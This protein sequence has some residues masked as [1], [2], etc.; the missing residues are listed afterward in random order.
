L[1]KALYVGQRLGGYEGWSLTSGERGLRHACSPQWCYRWAV[2]CIYTHTGYTVWDYYGACCRQCRLSGRFWYVLVTDR[3]TWAARRTADCQ[4]FL[5]CFYSWC[6]SAACVRIDGVV[7]FHGQCLGYR[8]TRMQAINA[9]TCHSCYVCTKGLPCNKTACKPTFST[10]GDSAA[11]MH[12][13]R[14]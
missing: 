1:L 10:I 5:S 13:P 9:C 4:L 2:I 3:Q 8:F 12:V 11:L 7:G 14:D 6:C